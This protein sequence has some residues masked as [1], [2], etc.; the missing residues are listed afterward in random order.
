M[1]DQEHD[2]PQAPTTSGVQQTPEDRGVTLR[3]IAFGLCLAVAVSLLG[4]T[5]RYILHASFM[6]YSHMPMGNLILFLFSLLACSPLAYL[7]GQKFVF[8]TSEWITIFC[9][10]FISSLGPTYGISG[11]LVGI[12]VGPYYFATP[13]NQWSTYL[14]PHLPQWLIPQNDG[15]AVGMFY[16]GLPQG[17]SI[18]W[19]VWIIPLTWWFSF[20]CAVAFA[21]ACTSIIFRKQW[22][23]NERLVYPA[24]EPII[25]MTTRGGNGNRWV[26]EFMQGKA[27]WAGFIMI[28]FIFGWNMIAWF[29]PQFPKFPTANPR[30]IFFSRDYPPGFFFLSTVVICFSY[31]A[32]LEI[33]FS[34]WFFDLLFILEGGM[35]NRLGV[36]AISPYYGTGRYSWQTA[37]GYVSFALWGIWIARLHLKQVLQKAIWP[38]R[39]NLD[40]SKE[41][42]SY[43]G[44]VLG[45]GISCLWVAIWL[46][47]AGME[48]HVIVFLIPGMLLVYTTVAKMLADSGLIYLNPP[49]S[50]WGLTTTLLGG[51]HNLLP[52][53]K[54][55]LG[56]S[57]LGINHY[58][59]LTV[60]LMMHINRLAEL[61]HTN[62]RRL[63]WGLCIA[64]AVGLVTSTLF[65]IWLG[66]TIGGYNFQPNWLIISAGR[67]TLQGIASSVKSSKP[68][69][70]TNYWFF[71]SGAA[72]MA[73]LNLMRYRFVWW[74]F[75]PLGFALSGTALSRLTSVTILVAWL[76]KL[77]MLK[78]VGA[79]F[80]RKSRPFFIGM[81]IAYIIQVALGLVVDAIWFQPQGHT[82]HQWY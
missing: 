55:I 65:T 53:T 38:D 2:L 26:P 5:V 11:Y 68:I 30:W 36:T 76:L 40:D 73:F 6:A 82:V 22:S 44:A 41:F 10:G 43:R 49:T 32:S 33:L 13:E 8:S 56:L 9:M 24:M 77:A 28:S 3:A 50:A 66:Y 64:F 46:A 19:D 67:G 35:L 75:H 51:S 25:E 59:G 72:F 34:I 17:A 48:L 60:S 71:L 79:G 31:F 45:L 14:H 12:L 78:L 70:V 61:I 1:S 18:P 74:P 62:K 29:Y 21:C 42:L 27:F 81:L 23:E 57:S 58:R 37:G 80:Y 20:L 52:S 15:N 4:N 16:E 69:E 47:R 7:F 54:A 63:F 39:H